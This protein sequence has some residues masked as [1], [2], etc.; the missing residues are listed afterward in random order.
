MTRAKHFDAMRELLDHELI[1]ADGVSCGMVDDI[2]FTLG[3][4][5]NLVIVALVVGPGAWE[6]R[7]PALVRL[8]V[9]SIAGRQRVRVPFAEVEKIDE[10]VR[11][12]SRAAQLALG[13]AD[14]KAGKWLARLPKT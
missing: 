2:E 7:L 6:A 5:G 9:R 11:L 8:I 3:A 14:R 1:D 10:V 4:G 12:K 13:V